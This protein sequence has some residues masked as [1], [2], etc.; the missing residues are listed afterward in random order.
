MV[1][2]NLDLMR[3]VVA[4]D[5]DQAPLPVD[6]DGVLAGAVAAQGLQPVAGRDAQVVQPLRRI[7]HRQLAT[8]GLGQVPRHAARQ[9]AL[10]DERGRFVA[11]APDHADTYRVI[12]ETSSANVT[13]QTGR[14]RDGV[15]EPGVRQSGPVGRRDDRQD[16]AVNLRTA[17]GRGPGG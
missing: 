5:E 3:A 6:P 8:R 13:R 12:R 16:G 1:V 11:E 9:A 10:E 2:H 7:Q 17:G 15:D 14:R 4:P